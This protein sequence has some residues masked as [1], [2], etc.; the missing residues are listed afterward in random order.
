[1]ASE[2]T[3]LWNGFTTWLKSVESPNSKAVATTAGATLSTG[4]QQ[5]EAAIESIAVDAAN[6]ALA[7]VPAGLGVAFQPAVDGLL[8]AIA[9][10]IIGKSSNPAVSAAALTA[11]VTAPAA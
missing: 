3:K 4:L 11:A 9:A 8:E 6:G 1:M 10:K 5:A 2:F 7:L